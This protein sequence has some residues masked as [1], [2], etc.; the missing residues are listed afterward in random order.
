VITAT[1]DERSFPYELDSV[2]AARHFVMAVLSPA[3]DARDQGPAGDGTADADHADADHADADSTDDGNSGDDTAFYDAVVDDAGIVVTE[4]AANAV[5]HA[6]SAFT[7]SVARSAAG[8]TIR[9]G[10]YAPVERDHEARPF[11]IRQ[12]HG[13]SVVRQL[14]RR[15]GVDRT[16]DG[17]CVWVELPL[18]PV[19][20]GAT[21]D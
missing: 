16:P 18:L 3:G 11:E 17:K 21:G 10:D 4:L 8:V 7:V 2:R 1:R 9:V 6:R 15:W 5:L 13:L 19:L 20:P 12:G 14:A